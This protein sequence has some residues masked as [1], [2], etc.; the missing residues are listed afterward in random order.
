M[1]SRFISKSYWAIRDGG[2]ILDIIAGLQTI[3]GKDG[4]AGGDPSMFQ[5]HINLLS[6]L[7]EKKGD[8]HDS[9]RKANTY[10]NQLPGGTLTIMGP[11][12]ADIWWPTSKHSTKQ[13]VDSLF[14]GLLCGAD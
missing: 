4:E 8:L 1:W 2:T 10:F 11:G 14:G 5:D 7:N 6:M 9:F 12:D 13:E 3:V